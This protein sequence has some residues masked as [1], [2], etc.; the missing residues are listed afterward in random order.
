[1]RRNVH[2]YIIGGH[3][4]SELAVWSAANIGGARLLEGDRTDLAQ[5]TKKA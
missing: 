2:A 3:G 4:D 5:P 1:M